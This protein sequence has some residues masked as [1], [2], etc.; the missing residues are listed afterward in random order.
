MD[1]DEERDRRIPPSRVDDDHLDRPTSTAFM[2]RATGEDLNLVSPT[3][4]LARMD[5]EDLGL[6]VPTAL[7]NDQELDRRIALLRRLDEAEAVDAICTALAHPVRR[8][9]LEMLDPGA[10]HAGDLA[11]SAA[12]TWGISPSRVSQHLQVLARTALVDVH[13]DGA[14]RNYRLVDGSADPLRA[15][16]RRLRL[17][18]S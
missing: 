2:P 5:D 3:A 16:L 6:A 15:W 18:G 17:T 4:F 14:Y 12:A 9:L 7:M 8:S 11:R 13:A 1:D 10:T